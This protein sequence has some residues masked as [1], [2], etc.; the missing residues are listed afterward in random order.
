MTK[1]LWL[2]TVEPKHFLVVQNKREKNPVTE[3]NRTMGLTTEGR[4]GGPTKCDTHTPPQWVQG[5][6][7]CMYRFVMTSLPKPVAIRGEEVTVEHG[8]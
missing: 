7:V 4:G 1:I 5:C 2:T 3:V 8:E 6:W